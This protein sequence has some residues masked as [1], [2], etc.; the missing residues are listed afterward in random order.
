MPWFYTAAQSLVKRDSR[1]DFIGKVLDF[2][3]LF[4]YWSCYLR[5][6]MLYFSHFISEMCLISLVFH[7]NVFNFMITIYPDN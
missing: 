6:K 4:A 3:I 7:F 5:S 1:H 2:L